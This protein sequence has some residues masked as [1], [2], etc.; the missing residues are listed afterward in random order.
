MKQA[1]INREKL[2]LKQTVDHLTF[3]VETQAAQL[4]ELSR[5]TGALH[6]DLSKKTGQKPK[7]DGG[8]GGWFGGSKNNNSGSDLKQVSFQHNVKNFDH[9]NLIVPVDEELAISSFKRSGQILA[10]VHELNLRSI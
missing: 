5:I 6:D 2:E 8:G 10:A 7:N 1:E 4:R 3:A 9:N